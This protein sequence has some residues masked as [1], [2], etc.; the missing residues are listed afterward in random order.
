MDYTEIKEDWNPT[1]EVG[2]FKIDGCSACPFH[3]WDKECTLHNALNV[4]GNRMN[5]KSFA[6]I[7][8]G[9]THTLCPLLKLDGNSIKVQ[10]VIDKTF[11]SQEV[12]SH[13]KVDY[14]SKKKKL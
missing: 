4:S 8:T 5:K 11:T 13:G 1:E 12:H 7:E 10:L 14:Y 3:D 6:I 9:V 2:I